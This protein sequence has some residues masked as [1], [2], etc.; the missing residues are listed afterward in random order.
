M[1]NEEEKINKKDAYKILEKEIAKLK[2]RKPKYKFLKTANIF[3]FTYMCN[4]SFYN[5]SSE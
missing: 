2:I 5:D 4:I 1:I 3:N